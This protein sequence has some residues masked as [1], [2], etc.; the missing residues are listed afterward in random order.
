MLSL[1]ILIS[2]NGWGLKRK[3]LSVISIVIYFINNKYK[4]ILRLIGLPKLPR[5]RKLG[6]SKLF[7]YYF[8]YSYNISII[9]LIYA[10]V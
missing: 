9:V 5:H 1:R 4:A 2:F 8:K 10:F 3:K 7:F 6:V